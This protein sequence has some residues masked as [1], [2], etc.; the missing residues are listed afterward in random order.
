[1]TGLDCIAES[2]V[3]FMNGFSTDV[4]PKPGVNYLLN[5]LWFYA[6]IE[7]VGNMLLLERNFLAYSLQF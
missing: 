4:L 1:M 2:F 6:G 7:A 5:H 3:R